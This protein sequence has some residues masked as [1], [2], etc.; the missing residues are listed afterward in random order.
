M[1]VYKVLTLDQAA[2]FD[3]AGEAPLSPADA[4]DGYVHLSTRDQLPG[5]LERHFAGEGA[6]R[7]LGCDPERMGEALRWEPARGRER[8]P[9]LYGRLRTEHVAS[10]WLMARGHDGAF[11]LPLEIS[12]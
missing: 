9:H 2:E 11:R 12:G 6:V 7:V 1:L 8:F 5:T 10:S 4:E 3:R